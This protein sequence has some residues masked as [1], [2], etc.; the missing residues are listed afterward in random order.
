MPMQITID[1]LKWF[2][3]EYQGLGSLK[4]YERKSGVIDFMNQVGCI[5]Y[6]P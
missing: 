2:L 1:E 4:K 3:I 6:D 5:Q